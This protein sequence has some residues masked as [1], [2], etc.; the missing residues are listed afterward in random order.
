[1]GV[2]AGIDGDDFAQLLRPVAGERLLVGKARRQRLRRGGR[3]SISGR[4]RRACQRA[5]TA[6]STGG[7]NQK[8]APVDLALIVHRCSPL[9]A[10]AACGKAYTT[11]GYEPRSIVVR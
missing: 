2:F 7:A 8:I 10:H 6:R 3:L 4:D 5:G 9:N 1:M 11:C